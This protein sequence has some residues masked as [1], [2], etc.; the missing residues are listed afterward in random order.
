MLPEHS[1]FTSALF[2]GSHSGGGS[3]SQ[4]FTAPERKSGPATTT[5]PA[6]ITWIQ[7]TQKTLP[8]R[9]HQLPPESPPSLVCQYIW[10]RESRRTLEVCWVCSLRRRTTNEVTNMSNLPVSSL[11]SL[12]P[13]HGSEPMRKPRRETDGLV[14]KRDIKKCSLN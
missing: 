12:E 8:D 13:A 5:P 7:H 4:F 6:L 3:V 14:Q 2:N 1:L 11:C 9:M 10:S